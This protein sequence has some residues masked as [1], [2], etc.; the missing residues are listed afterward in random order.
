MI[1]T[2]WI[3]TSRT[4]TYQNRLD[5]ANAIRQA[6]IAFNRAVDAGTRAGLLVRLDLTIPYHWSLPDTDCPVVSAQITR[7]V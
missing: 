6:L 4:S 5:C 7:R 3:S 1:N 2:D